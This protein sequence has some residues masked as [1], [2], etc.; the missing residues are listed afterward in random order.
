MHGFGGEGRGG[1]TSLDS[2]KF[3]PPLPVW[4]RAVRVS[5]I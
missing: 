3:N 1:N 4:E 5:S 2:N